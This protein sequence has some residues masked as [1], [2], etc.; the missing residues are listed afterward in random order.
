MRAPPR[1]VK[2]L[3]SLV[4]IEYLPRIWDLIF[5]LQILSPANAVFSGIGV[6]LMVSIILDLSVSAIVTLVFLRLLRT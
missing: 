3:V 2:V 1:L 6:L 5:V 4:P